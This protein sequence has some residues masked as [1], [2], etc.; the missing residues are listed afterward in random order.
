MT[1]TE[2]QIHEH[3][4]DDNCPQRLMEAHPRL[5]AA[6]E[7]V[8]QQAESAVPAPRKKKIKHPDQA[9]L[10]A[11]MA[12][13]LP[14]LKDALRAGATPSAIETTSRSIGIYGR[15]MGPQ[16]SALQLALLAK[17]RTWID[18]AHELILA[19]ADHEYENRWG[20]TAA[21]ILR[22]RLTK[23]H[24]PER[25]FRLYCDYI[26]N[27]ILRPTKVRHWFD[28]ASKSLFSRLKGERA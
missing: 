25:N 17:G 27:K 13:D 3:Q 15:V 12:G 22:E 23:A 26:L 18:C 16:R 21:K 5:G 19:G 4:S 10:S 1:T 7:R 9:L 28:D 6:I 24:M 11:A 14:K 8:A 2:H 20:E